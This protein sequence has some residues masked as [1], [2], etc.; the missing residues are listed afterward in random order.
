[1]AL[2]RTI[3]P[4][5]SGSDQD[6]LL[7]LLHQHCDRVGPECE[8]TGADG[9]GR[10]EAG[11]GPGG[12]QQRAGETREAA[13]GQRRRALVH[14]QH[15]A[16]AALPEPERVGAALAALPTLAGPHLRPA[17]RLADAAVLAALAARRLPNL[18]AQERAAALPE[19]LREGLTAQYLAFGCPVVQSRADTEG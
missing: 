6:L 3:L 17:A 9:A 4:H 8:R 5:R 7:V 11:L 13:H 1:M 14:D 18:R 19:G 2:H 12:L 16:R 15:A 10:R